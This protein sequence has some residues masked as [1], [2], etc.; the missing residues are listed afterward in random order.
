MKTTNFVLQKAIMLIGCCLIASIAV[1]QSQLPFTNRQLNGPFLK[2]NHTYPISP[3]RGIYEGAQTTTGVKSIIAPD[4]YKRIT[5]TSIYATV[6]FGGIHRDTQGNYVYVATNGNPGGTYKAVIVKTQNNG[7]EIWRKEFSDAYFTAGSKVVTD[8]QDN[9]FVFGEVIRDS[10]NRETYLAKYTPSGNV[11]W[12]EYYSQP[13]FILVKGMELLADS[14]DNII[15]I[16]QING[17]YGLNQYYLV[18]KFDQSGN[19][20]WTQAIPYPSTKTMKFGTYRKSRLLSDNSLVLFDKYM[21][22][23]LNSSGMINWNNQLTTKALTAA[24]V[25]N[26]TIVTLTGTSSAALVATKITKDNVD[27]WAT[28]LTGTTY[29]GRPGDICLNSKRNVFVLTQTGSTGPNVIKLTP[30][31]VVEYNNF[32]PCSSVDYEIR[33]GFSYFMHANEHDSVVI[34]GMGQNFTLTAVSID[35]LG[36]LIAG[37]HFNTLETGYDYVYAYDGFNYYDGQLIVG[38]NQRSMS[39]TGYDLFLTAINASANIK[40]TQFVEKEASSDLQIYGTALDAS[41]NTYLAG[42]SKYENFSRNFNLTKLNDAGVVVWNNKY[43][44]SLDGYAATVKVL[45]DNSVIVGGA[46]SSPFQPV[47]ININPDGTIRWSLTLS[48]PSFFNGGVQSVDID[49]DGNIIVASQVAYSDGVYDIYITKV[50]PAGTVI[51]DYISDTATNGKNVYHLTTD[52]NNNIIVSGETK[53]ASYNSIVYAIKLNSSGVKVWEYSENYSGADLISQAYGDNQGNT[54]L[55]GQASSQGVSIK[56]D[57][58]GQKVWSNITTNEGYYYGIYGSGDTA[59]Y[60]AGTTV[61]LLG[62]TQSELVAFDTSGAI[63]WSHNFIETGKSIYGQF[64]IGDENQLYF[65]GY[66]ADESSNQYSI[67]AIY[68]YQGNLQYNSE[69][70]ISREEGD[71]NKF[72]L[73]DFAQNDNHLVIAILSSVVEPNDNVNEYNMAYVGNAIR[74]SKSGLVPIDDNNVVSTLR[75]YPNPVTNTLCLFEDKEITNVT[76]YNVTG[77]P[78]ISK[79]I[80]ATETSLNVS[81]LAPGIYTVRVESNDKFESFKIIKK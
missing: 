63:L 49:N 48:D 20:M 71:F 36:V 9:I 75:Y 58:L 23:N 51:W 8:S 4:W 19:I 29:Q 50:S 57:A 81:G 61:D 79:S 52:N 5:D 62:N 13:D 12:T 43:F 3:S 28:T 74:F 16:S 77:Q 38:G 67:F 7:V 64:V 6:K 26:D 68:D 14:Q 30:N 35:S 73:S 53:D 65:S 59:V 10:V 40:W 11:V 47:L 55:V 18:N 34:G 45:S 33:D 21:F 1:A 80:H 15:A 17:D 39:E 42:S 41:N 32:Y 72:W 27:I 70:K 44:S 46:L 24:D 56:L 54:Y 60:A 25:L 76:I 22:F 66:S 31:G 2:K 69:V 37:N 78:V